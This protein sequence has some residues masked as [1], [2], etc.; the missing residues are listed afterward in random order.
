[1]SATE[2]NDWPVTNGLNLT[3]IEHGVLGVIVVGQL[4]PPGY[5]LVPFHSKGPV[6]VPLMTVALLEPVLVTVKEVKE[7]LPRLAGGKLVRGAMLRL[8]EPIPVPVNSNPG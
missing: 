4:P 1:M 8:A 6:I 5:P 3:C 2:P 7:V